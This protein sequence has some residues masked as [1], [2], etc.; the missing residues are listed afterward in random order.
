MGT[1]KTPEMGA[2]ASPRPT[3]S[4]EEL[5]PYR[6]ILASQPRLVQHGLL[7]CGRQQFSPAGRG[8]AS[9][10]DYSVLYRNVMCY[11]V[12]RTT[13]QYIIERDARRVRT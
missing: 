11:A 4:K 12:R 10:A 5:L 1:S 3:S 9:A 2:S 13:T 8:H 6:T 7:V